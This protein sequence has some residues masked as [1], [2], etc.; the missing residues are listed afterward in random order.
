MNFTSLFIKN[1]VYAIVL[2]VM[3][4][5][6]GWLCFRSISIREYPK[7]EIPV[8]SVHT[9]YFNASPDVVESSITN[10]LEDQFAAVENIET[11]TSTSY[12]E[13]SMIT[14]NFCENTSMDKA[15][16]A[17][18][19]AVN[20]ARGHLPRDV[21]EPMITRSSMNEDYLPFIVLT[22]EYP[23]M[24]PAELT[25]FT[26]R[27]IKNAFRGI[28][29]VSSVDVWGEYYVNN[30]KLCRKR[31]NNF[32][33]NVDEIYNAINE[34]KTSRPV[35]AVRKTTPAT[36]VSE[37]K[38]EKDFE[39]I[40]VKSTSNNK[41]PILL[42]DVAD[43]EFSTLKD[44]A[45]NFDGKSVVSV[46]IS[47]SSSANPVDVSNLVQKEIAKLKK[48]L[49]AEFSISSVIDKAEFV[50]NAIKNTK[51]AT[52][53]VIFLVF[54]VIFVFLGTLRGTLVPV[55]TIPIS[56]IGAVI[57]LK[58]F[59]FSIN[60][61]TLSAIVLAVGLVVDDAIVVLENISRYIEGGLSRV[62]AAI[63]GAKEIGGA[64]VAMTLTLVSVYSPFIF[65][66]GL[67][68]KIFVEF[69][70]ALAGSVLVSG[71]VALTLSPLM[72]SVLLAQQK[73]SGESRIERNGN[74]R[75]FFEWIDHFFRILAEK[76][77]K[78]LEHTLTRKTT[79]ISVAL[80]SLALIGV[81]FKLI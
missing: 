79:C 15:F 60:M 75:S 30:I 53:L 68:G 7:V 66:H 4:V 14:L 70:V 18:R 64:I 59:G 67:I 8:I 63:R 65:V 20:M 35:G 61:M 51:D 52:F 5:L 42:K 39:D 54:V 23:K 76:Y 80:C 2:N 22:L 50:K 69:A 43:V 12:P 19:E 3:L 47:I 29:G 58:V 11:I 13:R 81:F 25:H 21:Q 37:I 6:V 48:E 41:R 24:Q 55:I 46:F 1:P 56:L 44:C 16:A 9:Q 71:V 74:I 40:V 34:R 62:E 26:Q 10:V 33:V 31:L 78:F 57:F 32:G 36:L 77:E 28:E 38:S 49:P 73:Q 27:T 17:V 45:G 72:C